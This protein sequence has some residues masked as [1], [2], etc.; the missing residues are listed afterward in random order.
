MTSKMDNMWKQGCVVRKSYLNTVP[1]Q[2]HWDLGYPPRVEI[3]LDTYQPEIVWRVIPF[4]SSAHSGAAFVDFQL[5][6]HGPN[7]PQP[8]RDHSIK[9]ARPLTE[10]N[11]SILIAHWGC[12]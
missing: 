11:L 10:A 6:K 1:G 4:R 7:Q 9:P 8:V 5:V 2:S 3:Y 12:L